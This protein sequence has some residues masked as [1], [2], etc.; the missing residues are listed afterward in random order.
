MALNAVIHIGS[1]HGVVGLHITMHLLE[2]VIV[3]SSDC[4]IP[5]GEDSTIAEEER[6]RMCSFQLWLRKHMSAEGLQSLELGDA[7]WQ[8][9]STTKRR[10]IRQS[11]YPP[12]KFLIL[13][14]HAD[15]HIL[16]QGQQL[17]LRPQE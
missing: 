17:Q 2:D 14:P 15:S 4:I 10:I 11:T 8:G 7:G 9:D 6:I 12:C 13:L 3:Q 5:H 16:P 1:I